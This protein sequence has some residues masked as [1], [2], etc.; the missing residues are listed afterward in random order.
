MV[1]L[2]S[3]PVFTF[4]YENDILFLFDFLLSR[5]CEESNKYK[6][7]PIF[8][9]LFLFLLLPLQNFENINQIKNKV[10]FL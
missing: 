3:F 7:S 10:T 2:S 9:F 6:Q 1:S 8:Y 4:Y 5:F